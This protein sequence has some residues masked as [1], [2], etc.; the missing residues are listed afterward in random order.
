[1][2]LDNRNFNN[3]PTELIIINS[4]LDKNTSPN[5]FNTL[6][7]NNFNIFLPLIYYPNI[8]LIFKDNVFPFPS[9]IKNRSDSFSS[10]STNLFTNTENNSALF[11]EEINFINN[12]RFPT[13]RPRKENKDNIR[14]KIKRGFFNNAL[15]KKLNDKLKSI[16]SHY[17][18]EKFP[19]YFASDVNQKRNK[20]ILNMTLLEI[21]EKKE[22]YIHENEKGLL[23][24]S[25][26]LNVV[27]SEE[28]K[29]NEELKN[30]FNKSFRELYEEY[31]HSNE[32]NI[33]E[34]SR[35]KKKNGD[36]YVK[37]YIYLAKHLVEFFSQ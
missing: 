15:V 34:I 4:L 6:I 14:K 1:M 8:N 25:H 17:Y 28:V 37:N 21:F 5:G 29:E 31:V 19:Q 13:K 11:K 9:N 27:Q 3:I 24:Y 7:N 22:L 16:A 36:E 10:V 18:F 2:S 32:F 30:I 20:E 23:N 33:D 26:N 12:K 35:L